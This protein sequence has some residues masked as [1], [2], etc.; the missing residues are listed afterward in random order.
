[1]REVRCWARLPVLRPPPCEQ[2]AAGSPHSDCISWLDEALG[3]GLQ[4]LGLGPGLA[5]RDGTAGRPSAELAV[6]AVC[7]SAGWLQAVTGGCIRQAMI[8]R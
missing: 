6:Q 1:M 4:G 5:S 3:L 2:G 7:V 8:C